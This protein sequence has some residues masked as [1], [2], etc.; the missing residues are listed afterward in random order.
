VGKIE[1]KSRA[2]KLKPFSGLNID[3]IDQP[4][5]SLRRS[6]MFI[7]RNAMSLST[8]FGGAGNQRDFLLPKCMPLLRTEPIGSWLMPYKYL[9][10][11]GV[12]PE[13]FTFATS[14]SLA[15][16]VFPDRFIRRLPFRKALV[17]MIWRRL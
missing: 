10:P 17:T 6:E 3:L 13:L 5:L 16:S 12:K 1:A 15:S 4:R 14:V 2:D 11:N 8:P 9:T 7:D